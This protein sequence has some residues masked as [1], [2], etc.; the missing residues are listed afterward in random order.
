[1]QLWPDYAIAMH[2]DLFIAST[3]VFGLAV[4]VFVGFLL[5]AY[6]TVHSNH[7]L[8]FEEWKEIADPRGRRDISKTAG[9]DVGKMAVHNMK[10][11]LCFLVRRNGRP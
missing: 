2:L 10:D 9:V 1:M 6:S 7:W 5:Q 4:G 3:L 8:S 11:A